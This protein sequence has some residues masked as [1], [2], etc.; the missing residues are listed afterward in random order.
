[1]KNFKKCICLL[2]LDIDECTVGSHDCLSTTAKCT[3]TEGSFTCTCN[4]G[5]DGDGRVVCVGM[6]I[7]LIIPT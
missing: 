6:Y 7:D 2:C 4:T 3:N 1:M 5:Y